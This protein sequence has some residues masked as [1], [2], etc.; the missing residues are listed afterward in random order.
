MTQY[1]LPITPHHGLSGAA[2]PLSDLGSSSIQY[3][4]EGVEETGDRGEKP[5]Q[6]AL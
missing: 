6:E 1:A 5:A 3:C 4:F 2:T